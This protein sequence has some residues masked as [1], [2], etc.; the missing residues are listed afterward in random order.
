[1][2]PPKL[3]AVLVV[4]GLVAAA[5][6]GEV[7]DTR[8]GSSPPVSDDPAGGSPGD[9]ATGESTSEPSSSEPSGPFDVLHIESTPR[10]DVPSA[11]DDRS[12]DSFP[13]P[14]I[15]LDEIR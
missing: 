7:S 3:T 2:P 10:E 14:L 12:N 6:G 11:L 13:E 1:M 4:V 9:E 15:G 8:A 5:C